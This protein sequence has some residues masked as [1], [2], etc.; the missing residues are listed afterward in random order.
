M[1]GRRVGLGVPL[2]VALLLGP[3]SSVAPPLAAIAA[4]A[5]DPLREVVSATYVADPAGRAVHVTVTET[6]TNLKPNVVSGGVIRQYF[7][8]ELILPI[9][10]EA[11]GVVASDSRGALRVSREKEDGYDL[12]TIRLRS[13]LFYRQSVRITLRYDLPGGAPRSESQIRVGQAFVGLYLYA[14]G[15]RG[16]GSVRLELPA[17]FS[18]EVNGDSLAQSTADGKVVLSAS[19]I[20]QPY[21][22]FAVISANREASLALSRIALGGGDTIVIRAWPEDAEWQGRVADTLRVGTP[23]LRTLVGLDWPVDGELVVTEVQSA[24][25]E[26]YAGI[27]DS[28]NDTILITEELDELT[29]IHE[30][31][32]A[33]FNGELFDARWITEG[34]ADSYA[35]LVLDQ[36]DLGEY[37]PP[38]RP[39]PSTPGAGPLNDWLFP[40]RIADDE[41]A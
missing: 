1:P 37:E 33:W 11:T 3:A 15:D 21:E 13:S 28:L 35:A 5:D 12:L 23:L 10:G 32:H 17:G 7:Y 16:A 2:L 25:L 36:L 4:A 22:W 31:S 6:A 8:N 30:A 18:A 41:T 9:H 27:Y 24:A 38:A 34:L 20:A 29:I 26:G 39:R 14:W 19:G 40:G